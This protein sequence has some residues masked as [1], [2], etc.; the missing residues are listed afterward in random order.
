M[1]NADSAH[2]W[3]VLHRLQFI[4]PPIITQ[5]DNNREIMVPQNLKGTNPKGEGKSFLSEQLL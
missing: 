4:T 2:I 3:I 5:S 1:G